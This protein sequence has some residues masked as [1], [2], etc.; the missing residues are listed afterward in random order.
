M[1]VPVA[2]PAMLR[3]AAVV[4]PPGPVTV[5]FP[6]PPAV[7]VSRM[8]LPVVLIDAVT[9]PFFE[10]MALMTSPIVLYVPCARLISVTAPVE[11]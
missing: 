9:P 4:P 3:S 8:P 11:F 10:L 2:V 5:S 7:S 6:D 1:V